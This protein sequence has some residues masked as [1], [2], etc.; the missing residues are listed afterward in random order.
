MTVKAINLAN[1]S[2]TT[3]TVAYSVYESLSSNFNYLPVVN[4]SAVDVIDTDTG[5]V[6]ISG[7]S[8]TASLNVSSNGNYR[9]IKVTEN[10][11]TE[12]YRYGVIEKKA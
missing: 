12:F 2:T 4:G 1:N 11:V 5:N 10:G 3:Y 9:L 8:D 7:I 6:I